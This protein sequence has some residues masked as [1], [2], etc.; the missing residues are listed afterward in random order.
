MSGMI[1]ITWENQVRNKSMASMLGAKL[2][3]F[4][5]NGSRL[6]RYC[7]CAIKTVKAILNERPKIVFAQNPSIVLIT[8]LIFLKG[9][10]G[11]KLVSDAHFAGVIACNS[12]KLFQFIL[13]LC[14]RFVNLVIVTTQEHAYFIETI[15]GK[16]LVCE[17]PLPDL[18]AFQSGNAIHD[19]TIFFICSYD[20]DEPYKIVFS[21]ADLLKKDG[22]N[23]CATGNYAKANIDPHDYPSVIF[24]GY[25]HETDY[26]NKLLSSSVVL[27][28]TENENCLVCGAY[29]AMSAEKP[30][31]TSNTAS[32]KNY[33]TKG[34][35]F[36]DHDI[37]SIVNAVKLAYENRLHLLN[38]IKEWKIKAFA[39]QAEIAGN[40]L[41]EQ[42]MPRQ[43]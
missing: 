6:N 31:V 27:D 8:L 7:H 22:F 37:N 17:D 42:G 14:N 18:T 26:Y 33:F 19:K 12:N 34:T 32:L 16:A 2:F 1:W 13:N 9:I 21:A 10:F 38:E 3:I 28:L 29:E 41:A 39:H 40:I 36:T 11:Y 23:L 24:L 5:Y 35:V 20:V 4:T 43:Q 15:G 30:L 25:L